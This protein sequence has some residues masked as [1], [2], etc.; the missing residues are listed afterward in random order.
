MLMEHHIVAEPRMRGY[1][2]QMSSSQIDGQKLQLVEAEDGMTL[3]KSDDISP[4]NMIA[5]RQKLLQLSKAVVQ[6]IR[7]LGLKQLGNEFMTGTQITNDILK[8]F[9]YF[10]SGDLEERESNESIF[11]NI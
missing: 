9:N 7:E 4:R 1:S 3:R 6:R 10:R 11:K 5:K 8:H 2:E